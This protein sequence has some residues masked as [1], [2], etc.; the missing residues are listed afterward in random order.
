[1]ARNEDLTDRMKGDWAMRGFKVPR[2]SGAESHGTHAAEHVVPRP[3]CPLTELVAH[4]PATLGGP[5]HLLADHSR[6]VGDLAADFAAPFGG[7]GLARLAGYLHD[8]GKA[9]DVVQR[10]F[11]ELQDVTGSTRP[12]LGVPHKVEGAQLMAALLRGEEPLA[13]SGYLVNYGHHSG[14]PA[15]AAAETM[16]QVLA[17]WRQP[18][19][20]A[21]IAACM[22]SLTNKNLDDLVSSATLPAHVAEAAEAGNWAPLDLFTRMCHSTLVDADFLD[23]A[24]HFGGQPQPWRTPAFGMQ[25]WLDQF[26]TY[27]EA[28]FTGAQPSA[29]NAVRRRVF[30]ACVEGAQERRPPGIYRLPAPTGT[31]KTMA[32]AAFGLHHAACFGKERVIVAVPF[33]TITTQN[34]AAYR[35]AFGDLSA[36]LLEHHSNLVDDDVADGTWQRLSAPGWDAEFIVTTTVQLFESLFANRPSQTRKLH[37]LAN[38]VIVLDEVQAIPIVLLAPILGMLRE[39]VE[40]YGVTVLL[41]SATQPSFWSLPVWSGLPI[42]DLLPVDSVPDV[43]QRVSYAVRPEPLTWAVIASEAAAERQVLMIQNTRVD[44]DIAYSHVADARGGDD[45]FLLSKSMTADHRERVLAEVRR[46]LDAREPVA[47]VSTQ[48]IEAGVDL[49]FPVVFRAI[50]PAEAVVQAAGRCN[51]EGALGVRGGRVVV[52]VPETG[53]TPQGIYAIQTAIAHDRFVAKGARGS[54]DSPVDLAE[55]FDEVY[56]RTDTERDAEE[57]KLDGYRRALDFPALAREFRMIKETAADV[58]VTDHPDPKVRQSIERAIGDLR[59][60]PLAPLSRVQRRLLQRHSAAVSRKDLALTEE[61]SQG[62]RVWCGAYDPQR[63]VVTDHALTW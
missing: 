62:I 1:V 3:L 2:P 17:A 9:T 37:R 12:P 53:A 50:A 39:L 11:R 7:S 47:V 55:Y 26:R 32:S 29:L 5:W 13:L 42:H 23:T 38:S 4:T 52:W 57:K 18:E 58:V 48:L 36:S 46:R 49:D 14:I 15:K 20:T 16:T 56:R 35:Q 6:M 10:R 45:V 40:H 43:T 31:G 8:A 54:L 22:A 44:A 51:R 61:L 25:R 63:G 60:H 41:A 21:E 28:R 24:A 19:L 30:D 33:T 34:A 59:A 27:Y